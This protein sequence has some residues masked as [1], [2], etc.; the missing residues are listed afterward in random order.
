MVLYTALKLIHGG[1][2]H[3]DSRYQ[4]LM[5]VNKYYIIPSINVDGVNFIEEKYKE[6]GLILP[7]RTSMHFRHNVVE[8]DYTTGKLKMDQFNKT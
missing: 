7:K 2:V 1:I 4:N 5:A 3:K 8:L 6:T